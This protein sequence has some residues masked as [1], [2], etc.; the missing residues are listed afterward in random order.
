MMLFQTTIFSDSSGAELEDKIGDKAVSALKY[1]VSPELQEKIAPIKAVFIITCAVFIF[2]IIYFSFK[3]N[4]FEWAIFKGLKNFLFPKAIKRRAVIKKWEKIKNNLKKSR[5]ESQWKLCL[6]EAFEMF[7]G[8]LKER[9]CEGATISAR[10]SKLTEDDVKN[11]KKV[12][13][14]GEICQNIVRDP[15]YK[16]QKGK[17][18]SIMDEFERALIELEVL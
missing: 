13:E 5:I 7:E 6:I 4:Y 2:F 17:V 10:L 14:A 8:A 9:G 1:L 3:S 15:D 12:A 11:I 16:I 18:E